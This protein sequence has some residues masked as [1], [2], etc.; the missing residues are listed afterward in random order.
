MIF[1]EMWGSFTAMSNYITVNTVKK[2]KTLVYTLYTELVLYFEFAYADIRTKIA[3][4]LD[5]SPRTL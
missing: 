2:R 1:I 3:N 5:E 4:A